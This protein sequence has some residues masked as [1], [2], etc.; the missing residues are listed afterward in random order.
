MAHAAG[1]L[2]LIDGAQ[3]V[4]HMPVDVQ[5]IAPTSTSSPGHK[6]LG[7]PAPGLVG[8]SRAAGGRC[9]RPCRW[10]QDPRGPPAPLGVETRLPW[11]FEA[12]TPDIAAEIGMGAA[13]EYLLGLGLDAVRAHEMELTR[14]AMESFGRPGDRVVR[15]GRGP[16][17]RG[18][19]VQ[20]GRIHP[21]DVAQILDRSGIC[22]E[23]VTTGTMPLHEPSIWP[24]R[25]ARASTS[26]R[27]PRR[28]SRWQRAARSHSDIRPLRYPPRNGRPSTR[29]TS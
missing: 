12:G 29:T 28:S 23:P 8:T 7:R 2:V 16:A 9:R 22:V 20:P 11:K 24:P 27:F 21:H 14:Y 19:L 18:R 4:P 1:A 25:P 17:R 10:R 13:A 6:M 3:A 26:T 5:E 15:P